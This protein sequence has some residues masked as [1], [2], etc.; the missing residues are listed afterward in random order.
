L[1]GV[2]SWRKSIDRCII[3]VNEKS[4]AVHGFTLSK[5]PLCGEAVKHHHSFLLT[6]VI[7]VCRKDV[8]EKFVENQVFR[9]GD[10]AIIV[11][12]A[13]EVRQEYGYL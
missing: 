3:S 11:N 1:S 13:R 4:A 5:I 12:S 8:V 9:K 10:A 7:R 6:L 2:Y